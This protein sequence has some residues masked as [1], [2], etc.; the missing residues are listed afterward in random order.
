[1]AA[2]PNSCPLRELLER[3]NA[4]VASRTAAATGVVAA[5]TELLAII[6][7]LIQAWPLRGD[8]AIDVA[9]RLGRAL[10]ASL[11]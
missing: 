9:K 7:G 2:D 10:R 11:S 5:A 1:M 6:E 4:E 8:V 3:H